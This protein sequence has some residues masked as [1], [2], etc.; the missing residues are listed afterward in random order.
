L[1]EWA[2]FSLEG[3]CPLTMATDYAQNRACFDSG[4]IW[5]GRE[6]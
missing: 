6:T 1:R 3:K 4:E 2:Q 5:I